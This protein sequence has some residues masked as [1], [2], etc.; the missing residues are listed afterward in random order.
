MTSRLK[1]ALAV[2]ALLSLAEVGDVIGL[3][4]TLQNPGPAAAAIGI[5]P[6]A[7]KVRA[8]VLLLLASQV[9]FGSLLAV[10]GLLRRR[11]LAFRVGALLAGVGCLIYGGFQ[12][13]SAAVQLH[14][15]AIALVGVIYAGLGWLSYWLANSPASAP[16]APAKP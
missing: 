4:L 15:L 1:I 8:I 9:A 5:S 10:G 6:A 3:V 12:L 14:S 7:Q 2:F 16:P 13:I 11:W